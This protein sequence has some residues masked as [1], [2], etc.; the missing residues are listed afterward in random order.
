MITIFMDI[1][2]CLT[3]NSVWGN[4]PAKNGQHWSVF[5]NIRTVTIVFSWINVLIKG[6][7]TALLV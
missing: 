5:N 2:W 1:M 3:M 4:K 7:A 6:A